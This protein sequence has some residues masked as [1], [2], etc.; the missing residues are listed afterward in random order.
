[1]PATRTKKAATRTSKPV[2]DTPKKSNDSDE[3]DFLKGM[4]RS[5]NVNTKPLAKKPKQSKNIVEIRAGVVEGENAAV[6]GLVMHFVVQDDEEKAC[7]ACK[8]CFDCVRLQVPWVRRC[9]IFSTVYELVLDGEPMINDRGYPIRAYIAWLT[10]DSDEALL[11]YLRQIARYLNEEPD[12]GK[13]TE[14]IVNPN[15]FR[16]DANISNPTWS[17]FMSLDDACNIIQRLFP[18]STHPNWVRDNIQAVR[19]FFPPRSLTPEQARKIGAPESELKMVIE[20]VDDDSEDD[21]SAAPIPQQ[22]M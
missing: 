21:E 13:W 17:S 18:R 9:Q 19:A 5:P 11:T 4:K 2:A 12:L 3:D 1:M 7:W 6:S 22:E 20:D 16:C 10:P 8:T 14:V 15:H